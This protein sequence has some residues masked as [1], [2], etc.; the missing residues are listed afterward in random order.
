MKALVRT[1]AVDLRD[2]SLAALVSAGSVAAAGVLILTLTD[3]GPLAIGMALHIAIMNVLAPVIA[4]YVAPYLPRILER[5]GVLALAGIA[6]MVLLWAWHAPSV[7]LA[8]SAA[9]VV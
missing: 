9:P 2:T 4:I 1:N 3:P 5:R 6:Q 7:Q 8:A